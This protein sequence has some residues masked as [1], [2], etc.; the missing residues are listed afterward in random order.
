MLHIHR[1]QQVDW[2]H[3]Q[4]K[5]N[6]AEDYPNRGANRFHTKQKN[7]VDKNPPRLI[8]KHCE[9]LIRRFKSIRIRSRNHRGRE[10]T[11]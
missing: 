11:D 6:Q 7:F 2:Q 5:P 10:K 1:D 3:R 9:M 8:P 4:R